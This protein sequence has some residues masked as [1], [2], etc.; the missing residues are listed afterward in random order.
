MAMLPVEQRPWFF[1]EEQGLEV[2]AGETCF[3]ANAGVRPGW[4]RRP[5]VVHGDSG[6]HRTQGQGSLRPPQLVGA[7]VLLLVRA[8]GGK[9]IE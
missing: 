3:L 8:S 1:G 2:L 5:R 7:P 9:Q 4:P 6:R